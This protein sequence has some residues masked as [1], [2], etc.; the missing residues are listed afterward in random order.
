M[1]IGIRWE[2]RFLSVLAAV[3]CLIHGVFPSLPAR[4]EAVPQPPEYVGYPFAETGVPFDG[5]TFTREEITAEERLT[6]GPLDALGRATGAVAVIG[7][8]TIEQQTRSPISEFSPTGY[9]QTQYPFIDGKTLYNKCHLI[10]ARLM[11]DTEAETNLFTGTH[12]L[13]YNGMIPF[14]SKIY[15]YVRDTGNHVVYRVLPCFIGEEL[16]CRGVFLD[17]VSVETEDLRISVFC[18]N[19]Q[20][21][22]IIDYATGFS[23]QADTAGIVE[24]TPDPAGDAVAETYVLNTKSMRFHFPFCSSCEEMSPKNRQDYTGDRETLIEQ[25]YKPCGRCH[26]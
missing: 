9:Q 12:Y 7:P 26:P 23:R 14:E 21:G 19:V 18:F 3:F 15:A 10:A 1:R 2:W 8:Y 17:A 22:V 13:N 24:T 4:A 11:P 5:R 20:P 25:G 6:L 16:V